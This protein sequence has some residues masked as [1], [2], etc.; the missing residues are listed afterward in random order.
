MALFKGK[1]NGVTPPEGEASAECLKAGQ[2][3]V[4]GGHLTAENLAIG[5]GAAN[6]DLLAFAEYV[7]AKFMVGRT[8]MALALSAATGVP[9][10]DTKG[11]EVAEDIK[12]LLPEAVVRK[13][14]PGV[15]ATGPTPAGMP[16]TS[17]N[18]G[19][20]TG[21]KSGP[22]NSSEPSLSSL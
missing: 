8:E 7:M 12:G 21:P 19:A 6:G 15:R 5:I 9:A 22:T 14:D 10:V 4:E 18:P 11:I 20:T 17:L 3:L 2:M 13:T 16:S 1:E